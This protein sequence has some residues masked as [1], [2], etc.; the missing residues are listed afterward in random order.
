M[1]HVNWIMPGLVL[2]G[3]AIAGDLNPPAGLITSTPGPEPRIAINATNTPGDADSIFKITAPGSYY[4]TGNMTGVSAKHGIEI[5]ASGVTIDLMGFEL[6]GVPASLDGV[7][8]AAGGFDSIAVRNGSVRSW[9]GDGIDL[10]EGLATEIIIDGVRAAENAG[11]GVRSGQGA[12]ITLCVSAD[13][14]FHGFEIEASSTISGCV[15]R[16]NSLDGFVLIA[17]AVIRH[18]IAYSNNR[19]GIVAG[20]DCMILSNTS[21]ANGA[22]GGDGAGIHVTNGD[23][24]IEDNNCTDSDRG[25]DVDVAGN[26]IIRNTCAANGTNYDFVANN[27]YGPILDRTSPGSPVVSGSAATSSLG[28]T[29]SNANYSY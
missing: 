22:G 3:N 29:D 15:A 25:I 21:R 16:S 20:S 4:L 10:I 11:T 24:R 9:G 28:S 5:A 1:R 18:C 2:A 8:A 27:V 14:S 23:N 13:N 17:G 6:R 19:D 12:I 26:V 7:N